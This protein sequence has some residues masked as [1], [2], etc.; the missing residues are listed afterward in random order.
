MAGRKLRGDLDVIALKALQKDLSRRYY[1]VEQLSE[2]IRRYLDGLPIIARPDTFAYRSLKF[3]KRHRLRLGAVCAIFLGM[4]G[5]FTASTLAVRRARIARE[6][7]VVEK[8]QA[9]AAEK[10]ATLDRDRALKAGQTAGRERNRAVAE[11]HRADLEAATAK[12][13]SEFLKNNLLAQAGASTQAGPARK[14]DPGFKVRT[15]LDRAAA[16]INGRVDN[17]PLVEASIRQTISQT[18]KHLGLFS[19]GA[20]AK[21]VRCNPPSTPA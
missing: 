15:A 18:Y 10:A 7:A 4:V 5:G 2:D 16:R 14:A 19:E 12:A 11:K 17:E 13:I 1:S 21:S 8:N 9:I 3:A 20:P 6:V